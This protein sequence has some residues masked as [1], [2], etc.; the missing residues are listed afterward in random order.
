VTADELA[1]GPTVDGILHRQSHESTEASSSTSSATTKPTPSAAGGAKVLHA[2]VH[3]LAA[4]TEMVVLGSHTF[5][6][7]ARTARAS[8]R[9]LL[10]RKFAR[11]VAGI[12][13]RIFSLRLATAVPRE[14]PS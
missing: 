1:S 2:K 8:A 3:A 12:L 13:F 6:P 4:E 11:G 7:Q 5:N 10:P 14:F 9:R